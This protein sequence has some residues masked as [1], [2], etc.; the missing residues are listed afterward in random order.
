[1]LILKDFLLKLMRDDPQM[2]YDASFTRSAMLEYKRFGYMNQ[3]E[4]KTP[5]VP[6]PI[7]DVV[8]HMHILDT[9]PYHRD[10]MRYFNKFFH[11]MP[12]YPSIQEEVMK[13]EKKML[14]DGY[15]ITLQ[16]Y[17][18]I[19]KEEAPVNIWPRKN[20]D[21]SC[22]TDK[23]T[24]DLLDVSCCTNKCTS[25]P[26]DVSCCSAKCTSDP[27]DVSCCTN[28]CTSDPVDVSCCSNK[29]T[30]DPVDVSCCSNKCTSDPVDVSCC[31][32][33]CTSNPVDDVSCCTNKC[34]SDPVDVSCCSNK[35]TSDPNE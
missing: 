6:S 31:S 28:K 13:S 29:C 2:F 7:V 17:E 20:K 1:M 34:T 12:S 27:V 4:P 8:W 26:V 19:F 24:S 16:L 22:C 33:K 14:L 25:D 11:H 3:V 18:R 21:V 9:K 32:A 10:C 30:S 5:L 15:D 35:C 23:C